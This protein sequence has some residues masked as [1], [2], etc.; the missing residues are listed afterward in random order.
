VT[1]V[2]DERLISIRPSFADAIFSGS[3]TVEIRRKIPSIKAGTRLWIYVTKPVG[4]VRGVAQ[5]ASIVEGEPNVVWRACGPQTGLARADFDNYLDGSAKAY[6]IILC[7]VKV[8]RPASMKTLNALREGFHP[9]QVIARLT[10][11]EA[12]SLYQ[13]VFP[14]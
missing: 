12:K 8:G 5:V 11:T 9:P 10:A 6:G 7:A 4:E 13:H 14:D 1:S 3:K 2:D